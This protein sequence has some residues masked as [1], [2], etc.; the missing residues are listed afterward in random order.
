[1]EVPIVVEV[2]GVGGSRR[3]HR[4][5]L[6]SEERELACKAIYLERDRMSFSFLMLHCTSR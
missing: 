6:L 4:G 3:C 5:S 1:V 2:C